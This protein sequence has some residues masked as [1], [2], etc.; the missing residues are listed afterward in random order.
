[1]WREE[2]QVSFVIRL[3]AFHESIKYIGI[4]ALVKRTKALFDGLQAE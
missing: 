3:N 2:K 4:K 1:M